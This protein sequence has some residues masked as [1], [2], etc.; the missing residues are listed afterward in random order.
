MRK[1]PKTNTS[2]LYNHDR[3]AGVE[4]I[5]V[6]KKASSK[7]RVLR[8]GLIVDFD[9]ED[10]VV[11]VEIIPQKTAKEILIE[12]LK[13]T[14]NGGFAPPFGYGSASGAMA[15]IAVWKWTKNKLKEL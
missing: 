10:T 5:L 9:E 1:I 11:G 14:E 3:I 2:W 15:N 13:K 6:K 8:E 12:L 4:Y 7:Q